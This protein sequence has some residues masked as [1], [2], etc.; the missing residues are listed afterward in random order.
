MAILLSHKLES[1][2]KVVSVVLLNQRIEALVEG[3][4]VSFKKPLLWLDQSGEKVQGSSCFMQLKPFPMTLENSK[5]KWKKSLSSNKKT[6]NSKK[7][8]NSNK[9][10]T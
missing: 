9:S 10:T 4:V 3:K 8:T 5:K 6:L 2:K 1:E 7:R